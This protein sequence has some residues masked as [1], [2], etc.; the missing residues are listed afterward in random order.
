VINLAYALEIRHWQ[1]FKIAVA[2]QVVGVNG[3]RGQIIWGIVVGTVIAVAA[4]LISYIPG[5]YFDGWSF[6]LGAWFFW[7]INYCTTIFIGRALHAKLFLENGTVLGE[8]QLTASEE[9]IKVV[10]RTHQTSYSWQAI[11][12]ATRQHLVLTLWTECADGIFIPRD[13]FENA[14]KEKEFIDLVSARIAQ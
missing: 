12:S 9:G 13:A 7:L 10:G 2:R 14:A 5:H 1:D 4:I 8:R 3:N 11:K 6:F